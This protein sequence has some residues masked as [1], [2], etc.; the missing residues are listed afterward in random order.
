MM[1]GQRTAHL[2][3]WILVAAAIATVSVF[4]VEARHRTGNALSEVQKPKGR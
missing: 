4:A 1:R 2:R 3:I